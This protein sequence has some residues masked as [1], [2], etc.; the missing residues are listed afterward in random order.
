MGNDL[1]YENTACQMMLD[2]DHPNVIACHGVFYEKSK[3]QI[4][5]EYMD[6]GSLYDILKLSTN[7]TRKHALPED[8]IQVGNVTHLTIQPL[9]AISGR[10]NAYALSKNLVARDHM[11]FDFSVCLVDEI[12]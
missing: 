1:T 10:S 7:G 2:I 9:F 5:M 4:V 6:A 3:F 12:S 8:A 11:F